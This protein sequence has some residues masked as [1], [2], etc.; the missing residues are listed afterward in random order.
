[1][2]QGTSNDEPRM[3]NE[4]EE[5]N[6]ILP[7]YMSA[8]LCGYAW[9]HDV[10]CILCKCIGILL[11]RVYTAGSSVLFLRSVSFLKHDPVR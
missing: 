4:N 2:S 5:M 10:W 1:M 6:V 8:C 11:S 9:P 7:V 3:S